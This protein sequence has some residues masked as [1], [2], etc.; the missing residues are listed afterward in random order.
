MSGVFNVVLVEGDIVGQTAYY[1]RGAG[2]LPTASAVISDLADVARRLTAG[3]GRLLVDA[4]KRASAVTY[5]DMGEI[6]S[7]YYLRLSLLDRPGI[8]GQVTTILGQHG[9]SIASVL[10]K[11]THAGKH[12]PVIIVTDRAREQDFEAA[13]R[14]LDGMESVGGRTVRIRIEDLAAEK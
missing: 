5:R 12:V 13:L 7:R 11:E 10:Q 1:G 9:I 3:Q 4:P 14:T 2:R 8:L 6:A